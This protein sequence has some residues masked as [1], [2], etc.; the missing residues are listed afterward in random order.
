MSIF[1]NQ[2]TAY[3]LERDVTFNNIDS[4]TLSIQ[5][6]VKDIFTS[7]I[8]VTF[9]ELDS[10]PD[11]CFVSFLVHGIPCYEY[12]S[13]LERNRAVVYCNEVNNESDILLRFVVDI[14]GRSLVARYECFLRAPH[15]A[16]DCYDLIA[17]FAETVN[18]L[19]PDMDKYIR[20]K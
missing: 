4:E 13:V 2:F 8:N 7:F 6:T 9:D 5:F 12:L 19:M 20:H 1:K 3:L 18:N 11:G 17:D 15:V 10:E 16:E 14:D